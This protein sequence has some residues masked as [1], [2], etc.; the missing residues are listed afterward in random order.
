M[1]LRVWIEDDQVA[2]CRTRF[3]HVVTRDEHLE[4]HA[5]GRLGWVG[6]K[7]GADG[8]PRFP[9]SDFVAWLDQG[10]AA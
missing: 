6:H 8:I 9:L 2:V 5:N 1:M 3:G 7:E 10:G 4:L